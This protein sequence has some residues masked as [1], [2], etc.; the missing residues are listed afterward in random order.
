LESILL[1]SNSL[2]ILDKPYRRV[3]SVITILLADD[4]DAIRQAYRMILEESAIPYRLAET[5]TQRETIEY[6]QGSTEPLIVLLDDVMR[7][8]G[9]NLFAS[10]AEDASLLNR[11]YV[12]VTT[13]K[14]HFT[15]PPSLVQRSLP[16]LLKPFE[17]DDF[18]NMVAEGTRQLE[19]RAAALILYPAIAGTERD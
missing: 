8:D 3:N 16:I 12:I 18:F 14:Q 5:Q 15:L 17:I 6:I 11:H 7:P 13:T 4:S 10:L 9:A 1:C 2:Q 19:E